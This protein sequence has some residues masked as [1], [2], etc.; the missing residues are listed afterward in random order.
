M[1]AAEAALFLCK[2]R[3]GKG[4]GGVR[5]A[6]WAV[7]GC[8]L[9]SKGMSFLLRITIVVEVPADPVNFHLSDHRTV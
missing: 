8:G 5:P 2:K 9:L 3:I 7:R 4:L 6:H 1:S